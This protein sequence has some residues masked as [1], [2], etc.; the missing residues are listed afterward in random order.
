MPTW[1]LAAAEFPCAL[2][3]R[4]PAAAWVPPARRQITDRVEPATEEKVNRLSW[5]PPFPAKGD[6]EAGRTGFLAS[7]LK[8]TR[9]VFPTTLRFK[10]SRF[11]VQGRFLER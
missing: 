3:S 7:A 10:G 1:L 6:V 5:K 2:K 4:K 8:P 9:R 11:N